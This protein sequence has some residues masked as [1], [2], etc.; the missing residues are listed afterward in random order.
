M[1]KKN[2]KNY[3]KPKIEGFLLLFLLILNFLLFLKLEF[4]I[5]RLTGDTT[6]LDFDAYFRL[7]E[8]I[9]K[10]INPYTITYM[11]TLGPPAVF[12]YFLPFSVFPINIAR[13]L[14]TFINISCGFLSCFLL[15]SHFLPK[16]KIY[17]LL[18]LNLLL[19]SAFPLR[20][21]I[22]SGQ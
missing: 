15:A 14:F 16:G 20:F 3:K 10:G 19:F 21:F 11:Q 2:K 9:K 13:G 5:S 17:V 6:L 12:L 22:E 18:L 7:I 4:Y 8:N 1:G